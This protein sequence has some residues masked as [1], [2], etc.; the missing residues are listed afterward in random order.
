[1][2]FRQLAAPLLAIVLLAGCQSSGTGTRDYVLLLTSATPV[3]FSGKI[4]VD[5]KEQA[6]SGTTPA[7]YR[8]AGGRIDYHLT[9]GPE[10]GLLTVQIRTQPDADSVESVSSSTGPNTAL[11]GTSKIRDIWA[12]T[13]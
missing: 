4:R 5:G 1:M 9:Q 8:L 3:T 10:N 6:V 11:Q 13:H 2:V 12:W 7:E